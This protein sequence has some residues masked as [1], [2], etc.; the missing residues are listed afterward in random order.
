[1]EL[2]LDPVVAGAP[3]AVDGTTVVDAA[4]VLDSVGGGRDTSTMVRVSRWGAQAPATTATVATPTRRTSSTPRIPPT[5][6]DVDVKG[7][8]V[9]VTGGASGI[10]HAMATR[11]AAAGARAVVIAD[12]GA[13]RIAAATAAV[14]AAPG[15]VHG[16]ECDVSDA[17][18]VAALVA[19]V[20]AAHGGID[21]FCANAGVAIGEGPDE[22]EEVW[23]LAWH[24]NVMSHVYAAR[25]LL[26]GWL[27][28]GEGYFLATASAA[29]LLSQIGSAVYSVTKHGAV[30]FAEWL[31]ITY[32]DRG[33]R[34]SC[35]CPQGVNTPLLTGGAPGLA[36]RTVHRAGVVLEPAQVAETVIDGLAAERFLI[37]PQPEV[38]GFLQ[39]KAG[40][41][42]RWLAGMRRLQ[43]SVSA[44]GD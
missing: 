24:V 31:S 28:R 20:E 13:E 16:A 11:F 30:A 44:T 42:D 22:P 8:A 14:E 3:A 37:L 6:G 25:A 29:G 32:G 5:I 23:D 39:R 40:D 12:L 7:K 21:L 36:A 1:M 41:H 9:V 17:D 4:V 18:A 27:A 33:V 26:P 10:G 19:E 34:V 43:S 35:L 2:A 15:V 38:L